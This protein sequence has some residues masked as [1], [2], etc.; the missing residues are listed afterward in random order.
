MSYIVIDPHGKILRFETDD[1]SMEL[2]PD[3]R[4]DTHFRLP[5]DYIDI[6]LYRWDFVTK[7]IS[8][9]PERPGLNYNF[10]YVGGTWVRDYAAQ[11]D[12]VRYQ[13]NLKLAASDGA[14][15]KAYEAGEALSA[16]WVAYRDA[17]RDITLQPD[18]F[19]ILWPTS[20]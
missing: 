6:N 12:L 14:F 7:S 10:D 4:D 1:T 13:R 2:Q 19:A 9:L 18:P 3:Y 17:L 15:F 8:L 16:E 20:P 11:W 5:V